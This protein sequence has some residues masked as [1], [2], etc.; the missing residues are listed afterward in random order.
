MH[1]TEFG[2]CDRALAPILA[3]MVCLLGQGSAHA[4]VYEGCSEPSQAYANTLH[5][6][7]ANLP[8]VLAQARGGD[9]VYLAGGDYG[10]VNLNR[11]NADF[12]TVAAEPGQTPVLSLLTVSGSHW[13]VRGLT[14]VGMAKPG[15]RGEWQAHPYLVQLGDG[16]NFVIEDNEVASTLGPFP[17]A[18]EQAH[19]VNPS[20]G[21]SGIHAGNSSCV[22]ISGNHVFNVF[23]GI[24]AEGDQAGAH[25]KYYVISDNRIDDFAADG[26]DHSISEARIT[27]N[28]ITNGHDICNNLCIHMDGIQGWNYYDR[29]GLVNTNV[30]IDSNIIIQRTVPALALAADDLHGIT[31][32][33]GVWRNVQITNNVVVTSTWHG[34]SI[35]G[36]D[37]LLIANNTVV[38]SSDRPTWIQAGG[39]THEGGESSNVIVRNNIMT[40]QTPAKVR[41]IVPNMDID[42]NVVGVDPKRLFV[43]FDPAGGQFDL[44]LKPGSPAQGRGSP[45][46]APPR[47][48]E[49]KPRAKPINAGAYD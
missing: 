19:V 31:I 49:G 1:T 46:G 36:V 8:T 24:Q 2:V 37:H 30:V 45:D 23:N 12:I 44:H 38:A 11:A 35:S 28:L 18:M 17:W 6:N 34:I 20:A 41:A 15:F 27:G 7:T 42:H 16:D 9:I 39:V 5:A 29:L 48:I 14:V 25:G 21:S 47:D 22:A 43:K 40:A 33:D 3:L 4:K 32:F 10:A 26:I 13:R